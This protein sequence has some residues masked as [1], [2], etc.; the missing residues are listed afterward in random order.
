M[1]DNRPHADNGRTD[2]RARDALFSET[3]VSI[4]R[5][6]PNLLSSPWA[7]FPTYQG[8]FTPWPIRK[9]DGSSPII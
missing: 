4:T 6:S 9:T 5:F 1:H 7:V 3:G 8:L 2:G